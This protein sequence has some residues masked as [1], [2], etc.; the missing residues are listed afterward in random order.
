MN[1]IKE[2]IRRKYQDF[3]YREYGQEKEDAIENP[4][5]LDLMYTT[6][7]GDEV[8]VQCSYDLEKEQ[9]VVEITLP[10]QQYIYKEHQ[11]LKAFNAEIE[12][13]SFDMYYSYAHQIC[14]E[15]FSL[16]LEW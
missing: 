7:D 6:V 3:C 16:D 13:A 10:N 15:K 12:T 11:S 8:E 14:E 1:Q 2:E 9:F 4:N 5:Y